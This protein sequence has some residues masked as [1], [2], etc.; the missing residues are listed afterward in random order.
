MSGSSS[1]S[2][3]YRADAVVLRRRDLGEADRI[4]TIYTLEHGKLRVV[5]KGVRRPKSRLAGHL[6]PYSRTSLLLAQGRNLDIVTQASLLAPLKQLHQD[7]A[8]IA[9]AGYF[10]DL[11]DAMTADAQPQPA[12]YELLLTALQRLDE[13]GDFQITRLFFELGLLRLLGF[14]PELRQCIACGNRIEPGVNGFSPEGGVLCAAC[15]AG[16]AQSAPISVNAVKLLRLLDQAEL[17][18]ADGLRLSNEL[19]AEVEQHMRGYLR[20]V[21]E[22]DLGSASVLKVLAS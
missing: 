4:L 13:G 14:R 16:D 19:R 20:H 11:L 12:V 10:G 18:T 1:R 3:L 17:A 9:Y 22:R 15:R 5:A 7:E 6:E 2:R 21:L 8:R